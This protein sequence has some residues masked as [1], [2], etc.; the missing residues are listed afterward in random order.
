MDMQSTEPRD[1]PGARLAST[2][3]GDP[4][5]P[6]VVL[7]HGFTQSE[8]SWRWIVDQLSS[9]HLVTT[10]D[11]PGHGHSSEIEAEDLDEVAKLL[12]DT[13]DRA[14]YVG[15]SLG[16]RVC[17]T[18]ATRCPELVD[19]LVLVSASAGIKDPAEREARRRADDALADRLD[20]PDP[21][22]APLEVIDFLRDW[23]LQPIFVHLDATVADL[24]SRLSNTRQGLARSLRTAGAGRMR[25]LHDELSRLDMPVLCVAGSLDERFCGEA[26]DLV[27]R[28][29]ANASLEIVEGSGHAVHFEHREEFVRHLRAF[30]DAV[31]R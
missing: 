16:G 25:P 11:L 14:T 4:A 5:F 31:T 15:Y 26:E 23:L 10:V 21:E 1:V 3:V 24:S 20:P 22:V 7:V 29:G 8:S 13:T 30:L 28:I 9:S 17:L 18:L 27:R 19:A 2:T 12:R 6:H